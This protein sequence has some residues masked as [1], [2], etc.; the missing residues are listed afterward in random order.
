MLVLQPLQLRCYKPQ[1]KSVKVLSH[2]PNENYESSC[3][4]RS[5]LS[6]H[7]VLSFDAGLQPD[8]YRGATLASQTDRISVCRVQKY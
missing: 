6:Q 5:D 4:D 2:K 8:V 1:T 7:G 3:H